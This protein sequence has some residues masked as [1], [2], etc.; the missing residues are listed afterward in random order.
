MKKTPLRVKTTRFE[1]V[2]MAEKVGDGI[3][4]HP[5]LKKKEM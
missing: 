5:D 1:E 2:V 3:Y 4:G